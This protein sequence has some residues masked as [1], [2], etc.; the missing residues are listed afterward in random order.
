VGEA[1]AGGGSCAKRVGEGGSWASFSF[2]FI[3]SFC[4]PFIFIFSFEFENSTMPQ[5]N[6]NSTSICI[7]QK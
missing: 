5:S 3:L 1:G 6:W 4:S 7:K 2:S